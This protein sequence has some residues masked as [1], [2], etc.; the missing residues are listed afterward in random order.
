[1]MEEIKESIAQGGVFTAGMVLSIAVGMFLAAHLDSV[2]G[3][4]VATLVAGVGLLGAAT[5]SQVVHDN[6]V[7]AEVDQPVSEG[8]RTPRPKHG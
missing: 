4:L 1:M 2:G 6:L 8:S 7:T 3:L 5:L